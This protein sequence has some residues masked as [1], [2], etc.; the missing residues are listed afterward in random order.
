MSGNLPSA[1]GFRRPGIKKN[2]AGGITLSWDSQ[3]GQL[4]TV[5]RSTEAASGYSVIIANLPATPPLNQFDDNPGPGSP[6]Y[7]YRLQRK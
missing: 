5:L 2:T 3:A 6:R 1:F 7:F 4:F